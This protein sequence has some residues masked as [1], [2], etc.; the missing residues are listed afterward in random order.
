MNWDSFKN[1]F[2][3]VISSVTTLAGVMIGAW[4]TERNF[5]RQKVPET[6]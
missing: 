5:E 1:P 3:A 4:L 2:Q 6:S